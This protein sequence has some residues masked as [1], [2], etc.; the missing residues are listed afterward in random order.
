MNLSRWSRIA[1]WAVVAAVIGLQAPM[2]LPDSGE[3]PGFVAYSGRQALMLSQPAILLAWSI[4]GP[5]RWW[6]RVPLAALL[7]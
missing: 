7:F 6:W 1:E 2:L 5:G 4:L 3:F